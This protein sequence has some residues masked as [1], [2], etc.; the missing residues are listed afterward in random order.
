MIQFRQKEMTI[1]AKD[2]EKLMRSTHL[3]FKEND[4]LL[5]KQHLIC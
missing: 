5:K 3:T 4:Q 1:Y 2:I